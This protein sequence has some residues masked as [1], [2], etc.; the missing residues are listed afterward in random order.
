MEGLSVYRELALRYR[1]LAEHGTE[2]ELRAELKRLS[3]ELAARAV[4]AEIV[5]MRDGAAAPTV[6]REPGRWTRWRWN[7]LGRWRG[8]FGYAAGV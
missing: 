8:R 5:A 1:A 3:A 6:K 4:Q 2:G 7:W